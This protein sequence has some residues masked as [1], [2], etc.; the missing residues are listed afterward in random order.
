[1]MILYIVKTFQFA[2]TASSVWSTNR[3]GIILEIH[4]NYGIIVWVIHFRQRSTK[5]SKFLASGY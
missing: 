1:M 2:T 5:A 4:G 3:P